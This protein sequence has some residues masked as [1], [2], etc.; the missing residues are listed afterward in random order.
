MAEPYLHKSL[1]AAA[2]V[3]TGNSPSSAHES[4]P[5]TVSIAFDT[6]SDRIDMVTGKK[7]PDYTQAQREGFQFYEGRL[8]S[9]TD[10]LSYMFS[11]VATI[12]I[13]DIL[14]MR[15][16]HAQDIWAITNSNEKNTLLVSN[17]IKVYAV[18]FIPINPETHKPDPRVFVLLEDLYCI[19][20]AP[21]GPLDKIS[22][23]TE[24]QSRF[25]SVEG[26][27]Y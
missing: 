1:L 18:S 8:D 26:T 12:Q 3:S 5:S 10:H 11:I 24:S 21:I 17:L 22:I 20:W 15:K 6:H 9:P 27:Q 2:Q 4:V 16:I 25:E 14:R 23:S 19:Q 7:L 13:N